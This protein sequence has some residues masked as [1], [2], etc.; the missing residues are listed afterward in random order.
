MIR[1]LR[2]VTHIRHVCRIHPACASKF[3]PIRHLGSSAPFGDDL[4]PE[5]EEELLENYPNLAGFFEGS[6]KVEQQ[7]GNAID[8]DDGYD[9]SDIP[10]LKSGDEVANSQG[11][12]NLSLSLNGQHFSPQQATELLTMIEGQNVTNTDQNVRSTIAGQ[13]ERVDAKIDIQGFDK[14]LEI[15]GFP[16][17]LQESKNT[18]PL[19]KNSWKYLEDNKPTVFVLR[20]SDPYLNLASEMYIYDKM[21]PTSKRLV[22]YAN[23]PCIVIG[24]NQNPFKEINLRVAGALGIPILRRFSGGGTVVHDFGNVNFSYMSSKSSF[25]RVGYTNTLVEQM[26]EFAGSENL[27]HRNT[28]FKFPKFSLTTTAK[29]DVVSEIDEKKVSGS[30]FKLSKGKFLHHGTMLLSSDLNILRN[31][32]N[33]GEI[34]KSKVQSKGTNSIPSSV[35]NLDCSRELFMWLCALSFSKHCDLGPTDNFDWQNVNMECLDDCS[36][37][38]PEVDEYRKTLKD[39]NHTFGSGPRWSHEVAFNDTAIKFGINNKGH[40]ASVETS[41]AADELSD[42]QTAIERGEIIRYRGEDVQKY[43]KDLAFGE[44]LAWNIDYAL[45]YKRV[46]CAD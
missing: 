7:A 15:Y 14:F 19:V 25:D 8:I 38:L 1:P 30:A 16:K 18:T 34:R 21:P 13:K 10:I 33:V 3:N 31:L 5:S 41:K 28:S 2:F 44:C 32:L 6:T 11:F 26:N 35:S 39:W 23:S 24:K 4:G 45:D 42:L 22:L 37:I 27:E 43:V 17:L 29:G 12:D 20:S 9:F 40:I 46:G 36:A